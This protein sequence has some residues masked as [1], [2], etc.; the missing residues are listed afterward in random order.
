MATLLEAF[1]AA[2]KSSKQVEAGVDD[3]IIQTGRTIATSI[4]KVTANPK[5]TPTDITKALYLTPHLVAILREILATPAARKQFGVA[6]ASGKTATRL[7]M[8]K[9]GTNAPGTAGE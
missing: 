5:A 2:V 1:E 6:A 3:A 8:L 7:Q 4:D 9:E